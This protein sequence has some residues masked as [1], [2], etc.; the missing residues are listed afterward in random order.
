[1]N[2]L[3]LFTLLWLGFM[4]PDAFA[5]Q[6]TLTG[7]VTDRANGGALPGVSVSIKSTTRGTVTGADGSY[8]L[9]VDGNPTLVFSFIG[10]Q[11]VE[12]PANNRSVID[13]VLSASSNNLDEVVVVGYGTQ[14]RANLT[15]AVAAIRNE[16]LLARQVATSSNLLQGL[17]PGISVTQQSGRP[18]AD[19]ARINIRGAGS[20]FSNTTPL[21]VIDNVPQ[22]P[23]SLET[24][25]NIDP[26]NIESITV[27]K[28][29]AS[30]AIYGARAANGVII[31]KTKRGKDGVQVS[32]NGFVSQQQATNLPEKVSAV[33]HMEMVNLAQRNQTGNP[34]AFV[35]DPA[36]IEQYRTN[37]ADN[38]R[39]YN[40]DWV[41]DVLTNSGLMHNHNVNLTV[42]TERVKL[43]G[44]GTFLEQQGLTQNTSFRRYDL[45]FNSDIKLT[46]KLSFQGDLIYT[47]SRE[48]QPGGTTAEFI[49]RQML[50]V[51]AIGAGKFGPNQYGDAG[52]SN[53]RNPIAQAEASGFNRF[54]RPNTIFRG[55]LIYKPFKFMD[56]E[57][58][59][60]NNVRQVIQKRFLQNYQVFRPD[61][62]TNTLN[63]LQLYPGQN[64]IADAITRERLNNY[65][66]QTNFYHTIGKSDFRLLLGLQSED[67]VNESLTASRTDLPSDQ[68]Y[69]NVGTNN[70]NNTGGISEYALAS[71][72]GRFN[73]NFNDKY[74]LEVNGRYDGSSRFFQP[75]DRQWGFFPSA[76]VGWVISRENFMA[77]LSNAVTFAKIRAS[78]GALGNQNIGGF[79]PF[80]A[81]LAGGATFFFNNRLTQ[82]V[83]QTTAANPNISWETSTQANLGLDL[84]LFQNLSLTVDVFER[85]IRDMLLVRPVPAYT[86]VSAPFVN[87]GSMRNRGFELSLNY[88][89]RI[90]GFRYDLTGVLSDVRNEVLDLGGQDII[91]GRLISTPGQPLRSYYGFIADGLFQT[92]EEIDALN[93]I[94]GNASTP[95]F[96]ANTSPGDIK[97]RDVSGPEGKPDGVINQFDR[98][99]LGNRQP[100][101]EY[102]FNANLGWKGFDMNLFFQGVGKRDNYISGT[103]AW[104]FFASDFIATAYTWQKDNWRPDNTG[105]SYPRL[106]NNIDNNQRDSGFWMRNGSYLRLKNVQLGYTIP[107]VISRKAGLNS[108]R[109]Y[110]SGQNLLTF[111]Q[112]VEGFDPEQED[113]DGNFYPVMKTFTAGLN[114]RF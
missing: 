79:Y 9:T 98:V 96:L 15:G 2:R 67:Y 12:E 82:G 103:G 95:Y 111:D 40:T 16:D 53:F 72:F 106:T 8:S 74:L 66:L 19:G 94:D 68:P 77:G 80:A 64:S 54:Q 29:A 32:Y 48:I 100:R 26:N 97:Y 24:L 58:M 56:V 37:P 17:A 34:A 49:I 28:D 33:E 83:A 3:I 107:A 11:T 93:A 41:A 76:S 27:L 38:F 51:P 21:V 50:G 60:S 22:A 43:F 87:A 110:V 18:G 30:T 73:Y 62:T 6:R 1:M 59:F 25:N 109:V 39:Y 75:L 13:V 113:Q 31:V 4:G 69:I 14:R 70:L 36:L 44:A 20:I 46:D 65:L 52:Q 89:N 114:L 57:A 101:Y 47:N 85:K 61:L 23:G 10:Y 91:E 88:K 90:G 104:A 55:N 84:T 42:G 5:Q 99:V 71:F 78:Y 112:F 108:V 86:G 63:F 7:R 81:N 45:R 92:K 35:F 105:A 102:S